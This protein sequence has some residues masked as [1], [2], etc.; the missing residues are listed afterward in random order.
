[1][2]LRSKLSSPERPVLFDETFHYAIG[3]P[4]STT[5]SEGYIQPSELRPRR[6]TTKLFLH[7]IQPCRHPGRAARTSAIKEVK[8][9]IALVQ[10]PVQ[11]G[12]ETAALAQFVRIEDRKST[13]LN[14]S[15][16]EI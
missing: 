4:I 6:R 1:M 8:R 2:L 13:R 3:F 14:S 7:E 5:L 12:Y 11:Y 9:F 16:V 15:H 10:L